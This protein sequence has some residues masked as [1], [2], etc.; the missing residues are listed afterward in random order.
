[1]LR[2]IYIPDCNRVG[3]PIPDKYIGTELEILVFP[4]N[5][6]LTSD[7]KKKIP[8]VDKSFG[9]WADMD[10]TTEE[11]CSEVRTSRTF[12]KRDLIL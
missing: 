1:M 7:V 9:G 10:R 12:R 6:I 11:I 3:F 4:V 5:D 8:D 2:T